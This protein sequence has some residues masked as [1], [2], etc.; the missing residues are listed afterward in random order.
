M[1]SMPTLIRRL[2]ALKDMERNRECYH[3]SLVDVIPSFVDVS[4][5]TKLERG[6]DFLIDATADYGVS[7]LLT[8]V[9]ISG[10]KAT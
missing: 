10:S 8:A 5:P 9:K 1:R 6:L 4:L 3:D 2:M 7:V